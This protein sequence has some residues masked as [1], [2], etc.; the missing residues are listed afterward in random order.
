LEKTSPSPPTPRQTPVFSSVLDPPSPE[1]EHVVKAFPQKGSKRASKEASKNRP[2]VKNGHQD[3]EDVNEDLDDTHQDLEDTH[4]DLEEPTNS[5]KRALVFTK[6]A[7]LTAGMIH[8]KL[9]ELP[10]RTGLLIAV[11]T[12]IVNIVFVVSLTLY[13]VNFN[14]E[15]KIG[16][17]DVDWLE[18]G[19]FKPYADQ[20][21]APTY[22]CASLLVNS[23]DGGLFSTPCV[24]SGLT[25][26]DYRDNRCPN[27]GYSEYNDKVFCG[28]ICPD[29]DDDD[30]GNCIPHCQGTVESALASVV[31]VECISFTVAFGSSLGY[32]T[33]TQLVLLV[34]FFGIYLLW[35]K[36]TGG[37]GVNIVDSL[38]DVVS[39][40]LNK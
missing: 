10:P 19:D 5:E 28:N 39:T 22:L 14:C 1:E 35:Q 15:Q 33:Y 16:V 20:F 11:A 34:V 26:K 25:C 3:L 6:G 17:V 24:F 37:S 40:H 29:D 27:L 31:Y 4:Q 36:R 38:K 21:K 9:A 8:P 18:V 7:V 13:S 30:D 2:T 32:V 12:V 23:T